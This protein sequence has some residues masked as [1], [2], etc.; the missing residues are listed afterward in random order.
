[1]KGLAVYGTTKAGIHYFNQALAKELEGTPV[2]SGS[3]S[4]GMVVTDM[5]TVQEVGGSNPLAPTIDRLHSGNSDVKGRRFGL[6]VILADP[7]TFYI[8]AKITIR[9]C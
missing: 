1:V 2:I 6:G 9:F 7:P 8:E 5:L 4:P 3:L